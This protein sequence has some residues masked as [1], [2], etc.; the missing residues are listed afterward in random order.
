MA[1]EEESLLK[2]Y[3]DVPFQGIGGFPGECNLVGYTNRIPTR[4]T[5]SARRFCECG[6]ARGSAKDPPLRTP[7]PPAEVVLLSH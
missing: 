4:C 2:E 7:S 5:F 3:T 1:E 6:L